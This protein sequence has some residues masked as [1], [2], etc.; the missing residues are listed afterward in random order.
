MKTPSNRDSHIQAEDAPTGAQLSKK[1]DPV[2]EPDFPFAGYT[3]WPVDG[4]DKAAT[5]ATQAYLKELLGADI[6]VVPS[7]SADKLKLFWWIID[8]DCK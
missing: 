8:V 6:F 1:A 3:V 2:A 5:D 4:K 7:F